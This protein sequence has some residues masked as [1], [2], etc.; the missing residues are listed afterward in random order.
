MK[1]P[2]P[3]RLVVTELGNIPITVHSATRGGGG[4]RGGGGELGKWEGVERE[5]RGEGRGRG[6]GEREGGEGRGRGKEVRLY[7]DLTIK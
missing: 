4:G 6:E 5:G 2:N 1:Q 7:C 3:E